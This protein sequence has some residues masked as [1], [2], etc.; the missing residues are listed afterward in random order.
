[1]GKALSWHTETLVALADVMSDIDPEAASVHLWQAIEATTEPR[2][3]A[4]LADRL[5]VLSLRTRRTHTA[6]PLLCDVLDTLDEQVDDEVR[7]RLASVTVGVGLHTASTV[8]ATLRRARTMPVPAGDTPADRLALGMLATM[9]M[10][11]GGTAA[12]AAALARAATASVVINHGP[13]LAAAR[14]LDRAGLPEE[15]LATLDRIVA[16]SRRDGAVR[17]HCHALATRAAVVA[18]MGRCAEAAADAEAAMRIGRDRDWT[19]PRIAFAAVLVDRGEHARAV[20]LLDEVREADF[21]FEHHEAL[22]LRARARFLLGDADGA[23]SSLR[24]CGRS[25]A[26]A[27]IRNP[28]LA[29][30]WL[31]AAV[32]LAVQGRH[33]QARPLVEAQTEALT[34]WGTPESV[35]LGQLATGLVTRGRRGLDLMV[36]AVERLADSP[37]RLSQLH[38]ELCL[39]HS[40]LRAGDDAGARKYLHRAVDL[41]VRCGHATIRSAATALLTAAGGRLRRR[42]G[43]LTAAER[44]VAAHA[45]VGTANR[46]IARELFVSVRT[47]ET[48]LSSVYRKLGVSSREEITPALREIATPARATTARSCPTTAE[49]ERVHDGRR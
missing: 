24:R 48:H 28:M 13:L 38:A 14:I 41:A 29:P 26:E 12:Q 5:G 8:P 46:E 11:D 44:R 25:L 45:A 3:R 6:F 15:A 23:L 34:R 20:A 33:D 18:G 31:T 35:G 42:G 40:L 4:E 1:V 17:T 9:T 30:W 7:G 10:M 21:V 39:G 16:T 43:V 47:V 36:A 27:G 37:A 32:V 2:T 19:A 22:V 49:R